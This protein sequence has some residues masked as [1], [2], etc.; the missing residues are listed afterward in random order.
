MTTT[1][2]GVEE[3]EH[4]PRKQSMILLSSIVVVAMCG[5]IY[6]LIIGTVSSYLL[7]NSV[8]QFSLTIGFFMFAMGVG[9]YASRFVMKNLIE[10]F[11]HVELILALIGGLCSISL[12]L[13][14][15]AAPWLYLVG[16]YFFICSIGFLVGL[17]IPI[18]TRILADR[19]TTR[20]SLSDVLSLDYIGALGGS[21]LF[22]ILLLPSLGLITSSFAI[23]LVNAAVALVSVVFLREHL[24]NPNRSLALVGLVTAT[25]FAMTLL[26]GRLTGWAQDHLYFDQVVWKKQSQYQ[27]LVVTNNW[28]KNDIRLYID[29]HLQFAETDEYRYHEALVHPVMAEGPPAETVLILG[30][31]DGLAIREVLKHSSVRQIDLVDLDPAMTDLGRE[32]A[33]VARL[34]EGALLDARVRVINGDA[35]SYVRQTDEIY[36]RVIID[37]PDPHNEA[38]AKLYSVEFYTMVRNVMAPDGALISQS[39]SPFFARHTYWTVGE[40]LGEV[41]DHQKAFQISIP[42]FGVWGFHIAKASDTEAY[43]MP[44]GLRFMAQG[45][46]DAAQHFPTDIS[47]PEGLEPNTIFRPTIYHTYAKDLSS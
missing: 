44:E 46:F 9:S 23:G 2:I 16:K 37:F 26:A 10:A 47:K 19:T 30:G 34:N 40:T 7:G 38:L 17:E 39:S 4:L 21:V 28:Q 22:P 43:P 14:F 11:I 20:E 18:L 12:F 25:L 3:Y 42:S 13:L 41:F 33:P 29:G 45:V 24:A 15:P 27:S 6:E 8:Y 36:D 5:I 31:G 32:F 35:F 1:E